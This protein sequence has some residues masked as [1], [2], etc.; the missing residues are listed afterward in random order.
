MSVR[1]RRMLLAGVAA[2]LG[3]SLAG[4][5]CQHLG[6]REQ[7]IAA[8]P[9]VAL[10]V[11]TPAG[12]V[13]E[14]VGTTAP[15]ASLQKPVRRP[16]FG[17]PAAESGPVLASTDASPPAV[18]TTAPG[19]PST[20][21]PLFGGAAPEMGLASITTPTAG[22]GKPA[23]KWT[24]V[25]RVSGETG[26]V[27]AD[28]GARM[29]TMDK[30]IAL[31][32]VPATGPVGS[33]VLP[34]P[35][36]AGTEEP[37]KSTILP[38]PRQAAAP[39]AKEQLPPPRT[40]V[41]ADAYSHLPPAGL[42]HPVAAPREFEK[43]ALSTYIIEPPDVLQIEG[44]ADLLDPDV[45][46]RDKKDEVR[47][48]PIV[49]G[50]A[51]VRPD[52]TIGLGTYGNVFV[53]GMT[54]EQ[55]KEQ[56]ARL[57]Q[58]RQPKEDLDTIKQKLKV[59][60]AAFNSKFYYVIADG[61]GYGETVVRVPCTGNETVLDAISQIQGLPAVASK[62]RVWLARATPDSH[63]PHVLP[64]DWM[65]IAMRGSAATNY[66][67]FPGDRIYI[68]SDKLLTTASIVGKVL[69]PV[70]RILGVTLLGSSVVN[71]IRNGGRGVGGGGFVP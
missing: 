18:V 3:M 50:P 59:D 35:L 52:G 23:S 26:V 7:P 31:A 47:T 41:K 22:P 55:A 13:T 21:R 64:V 12:L 42:H 28:G 46:A 5:G 24:T 17:G 10:L 54:L 40:V 70:E 48:R 63:H 2:V 8:P 43:R 67:V 44:A 62:K 11:P 69:A 9:H 16:L 45:G 30:P 60:V 38:A 61:A 19:S 20:R 6:L 39:P 15:V 36:P 66:Q 32:S 37:P 57:I 33:N 25:R 58:T 53:A 51:L 49:A 14:S 71:S 4:T 68:H 56:I 1:S 34:A 65:G 27:P 29:A